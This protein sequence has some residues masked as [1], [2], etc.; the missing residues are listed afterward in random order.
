MTRNLTV[1]YGGTSAEAEVS[2]VSGELVSELLEHLGHNVRRARVGSD[3]FRELVSLKNSTEGA[4]IMLHGGWGEDGTIQ[5]CLDLIG[6]PYTGSR[7]LPSALAMHKDIAK[8][9]FR[10]AGIPTLSWRTSEDVGSFQEAI[11]FLGLPCVIKP[12]AEGSSVGVSLLKRLPSEGAISSLLEKNRKVLIEAYA[13]G[14]ILTVPVIDVPGYERAL[15][16]IQ[17]IPTRSE[18][19]DREAKEE[20]LREYNLEPPLDT[21]ELQIVETVS[22]NAHRALGCS[23]VTRVDLI[24][25]GSGPQILEVNTIPGMGPRGNLISA[26]EAQGLDRL[27]L[28]DY[29][30]RSIR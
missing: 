23:G 11:E 29:I 14:M 24:Y 30:V 1:L 12:C 5:A 27:Q 13:P 8:A 26:C 15:H 7:A 4:V 10:Q 21:F 9:L 16:P 28:V 6:I 25:A 19:Y 18:L 2:I 17:I 20:G 22:W 3:P